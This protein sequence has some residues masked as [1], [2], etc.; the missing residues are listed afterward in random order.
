MFTNTFMLLSDYLLI[1]IA[2]GVSTLLTGLGYCFGFY[3]GVMAQRE[4]DTQNQK[5]VLPPGWDKE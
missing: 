1:F 3:R 4:A 2:C 5:S